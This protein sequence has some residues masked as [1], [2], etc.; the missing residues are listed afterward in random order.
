MRRPFQITQLVLVVALIGSSVATGQEVLANFL[1]GTDFSKYHTY[2][3]ISIEGGAH[4][5]QSVDARIKQSFDGQLASKGMSRSDN[6]K[7]DL[8]VGYQAAVDQKKDWKRYGDGG[9][10]GEM[11][12]STSPTLDAGT[13]VLD[14]YDPAAKLLIW[15]G[16]A[17]KT[18]DPK[19]NQEENAKN[20]DKAT[21]KLLR[22]YPPK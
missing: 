2:K 10:W 11:A 1:L 5:N 20:L 19:D 15:T 7:A 13:L 4:S 6:D 9:S 3:W 16:T 22:N 14:I 18:L 8:Y 21:E 17:T 12:A